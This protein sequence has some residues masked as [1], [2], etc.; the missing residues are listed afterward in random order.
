MRKYRRLWDTYRF[1]GFRPSSTVRGIF[2]D[3]K[4]R[5]LGLRRRGKNGLRSLRL[6]QARMVRSQTALGAGKV[7]L[8]FVEGLNNK[9]RVIQRRSYGLRDEE[10]LRLKILTCM[11]EPI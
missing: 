6:Y 9:I 2:G 5:T 8:G 1:P 4:A 3:P 7:A 10:Y 11:L